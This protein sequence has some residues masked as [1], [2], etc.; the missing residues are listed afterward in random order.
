MFLPMLAVFSQGRAGVVGSCQLS[1]YNLL[2]NF[3]L[4]GTFVSASRHPRFL[5]ASS[6]REHPL[7]RPH[8]EQWGCW[9][10]EQGFRK[11]GC[12]W[13]DSSPSL[14]LSTVKAQRS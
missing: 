11:S 13:I 4:T 3:S 8:G 2:H 7:A 12:R 14:C 10:C 1:P 5:Q 6:S 9:Y